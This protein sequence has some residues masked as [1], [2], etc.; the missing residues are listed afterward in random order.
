MT[1][2]EIARKNAEI[3]KTQPPCCKC[4][5]SERVGDLLFCTVTGKGILPQHE[6]LCLCRGERLKEDNK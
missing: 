6:S 4:P 1:P 3:E 2:L 5:K